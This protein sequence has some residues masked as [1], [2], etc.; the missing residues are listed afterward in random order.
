MGI[1]CQW[2]MGLRWSNQWTTMQVQG[3]YFTIILQGILTILWTIGYAHYILQI[4]NYFL[5]QNVTIQQK[6]NHTNMNNFGH[7]HKVSDMYTL[8]YR[9]LIIFY[10]KFHNYTKKINHTIWTTLVMLIWLSC[11]CM[12]VWVFGYV[13]AA[14]FTF[15]F[16]KDLSQSFKTVPKHV[17]HIMHN[18]KVQNQNQLKF[19]KFPFAGLYY[20]R[21]R[22]CTTL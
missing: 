20:I 16:Y 4:I 10:S 8:F 18:S 1:N 9:S 6:Y 14:G 17:L 22:S 7:V 13:R 3:A 2:N 5:I 21:L 12:G 15:L 19:C 11:V